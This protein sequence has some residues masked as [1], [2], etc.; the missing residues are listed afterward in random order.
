MGT[1]LSYT[2]FGFA[3][4]AIGLGYNYF[5]KNPSNPKNKKFLLFCLSS[6][7]WSLGF[8]FLIIQSTVNKA[9]LCRSIGMMGVFPY[10]YFG[11]SLLSY[12]AESSIKEKKLL[13]RKEIQKIILKLENSK[14]Y[15]EFAD[16]FAKELSKKG[17]SQQRGIWKKYFHG[18]SRC[19]IF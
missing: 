15:K 14:K 12:L 1:I 3:V 2:I 13:N 4:C 8:G 16:K 7:L 5:I 17:L 10:I 6:A 11:L 19:W 18:I 9:W